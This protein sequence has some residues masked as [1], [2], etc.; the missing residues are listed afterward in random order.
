MQADFL[1]G[2]IERCITEDQWPG[3]PQ[4]L[5]AELLAQLVGS[6]RVGGGVERAAG[7][8]VDRQ[9]HQVGYIL[10]RHDPKWGAAIAGNL[11]A[12]QKRAECVRYLT[13]EKHAGTQTTDGNAW[14]CDLKC[15]QKSFDL[16]F[17]RGIGESGL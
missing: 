14:M 9:Q 8:L 15:V 10:I 12:A 1:E 3:C 5:H 6:T 16:K 13:P 17:A 7:A 4:F 2:P 11:A